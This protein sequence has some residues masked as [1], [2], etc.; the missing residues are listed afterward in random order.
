MCHPSRWESIQRKCQRKK[1]ATCNV[2]SVSWILDSA[3]HELSQWA[4]GIRFSGALHFSQFPASLSTALTADS[5]NVS[6]SSIWLSLFLKKKKKQDFFF[7]LIFLNLRILLSFFS[8]FWVILRHNKLR[9]QHFT[10][11]YKIKGDYIGPATTHKIQVILW[12]C[13]RDLLCRRLSR[14]F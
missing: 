8:Q 12:K 10:T 11:Q 3:A 14:Q 6:F 1:E 2:D 7:P 4:M 9:C 5:Y 13:C